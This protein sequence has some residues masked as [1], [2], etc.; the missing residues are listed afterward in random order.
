MVKLIIGIAIGLL[1]AWNYLPNQPEIVTV[2]WTKIHSLV[3][4]L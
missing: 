4:S 3:S 1:I 2:I